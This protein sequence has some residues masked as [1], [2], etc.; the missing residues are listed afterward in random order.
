MGA[1]ALPAAITLVFHSIASGFLQD[2]GYGGSTVQ[3]ELFF[4]L[5]VGDEI[6]PL[7]VA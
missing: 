1:T 2:V 6:I 3:V 4:V 7:I 5:S